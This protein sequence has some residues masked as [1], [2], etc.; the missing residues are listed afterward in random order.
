M[1]AEYGFRFHHAEREKAVLNLWLHDVT[2]RLPHYATHQ[3]GVA[4]S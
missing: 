2:N 4:G 1:A 3:L